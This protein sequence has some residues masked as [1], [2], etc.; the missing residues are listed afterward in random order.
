MFKGLIKFLYLSFVRHTKNNCTNNIK[1]CKL[2]AN[3]F[4]GI[5]LSPEK[6]GVLQILVE[7]FQNRFAFFKNFTTTNIIKCIL[8]HC[9]KAYRYADTYTCCIR[10]NLK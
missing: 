2:Y 6:T 9:L 8:P 3:Y 4:Y 5:L 1:E 10:N 7:Y